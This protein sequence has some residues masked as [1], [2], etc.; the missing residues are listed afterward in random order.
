MKKTQFFLF[1]TLLLVG[2]SASAQQVDLREIFFYDFITFYV[3]SVDV[4]TG[5]T[6]VPIFEYE[7]TSESYPVWVAI[8]LGILVNSAALGLTYDQPFMEVKTLPFKLLAAIRIKNT[9][10]NMNTETLYDI[11]GDRVN[12]EIDEVNTIFDDPD[13]DA[14]DLQGLIIQSGR[15]PDGMYRFRMSIAAWADD[16][17][18][19]QPG[20]RLSDV[21]PLDRTIVA[22]YPVSLELIAP[23]GLLEDT[24]NTAI[25]TTYPFFQWESDPCAICTYRIRV[26][27][28]IPEEHSSLEDAIEDQTVLPLDQSLGYQELGSGTSFQYPLTGA[29][30]LE[31]G[32]IYAWQV[33]KAIP[34]TERDEEIHSFIYAFKIIDPTATATTTA[35]GGVIQDPVLQFLFNVMGEETYNNNFGVEGDLQGFAPNNVII[36]NGE[37]TNLSGLN[38]ISNAIGQ[39]EA[40]IIN[41]E[42]Q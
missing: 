23:G 6:D 28:F 31:P 42:V 35:E 41:V 34:T 12:V 10:L 30:D 16:A 11:H 25:T 15:L 33:Q 3:S 40:T 36:I 20:T 8:D 1:T 39:G 27:E 29:V 4:S 9:E 38:E 7:L 14:D 13:Y 24:T 17:G 2:T 18:G 37:P 5:A 19:D 32:H 26:A 21:P 22:S